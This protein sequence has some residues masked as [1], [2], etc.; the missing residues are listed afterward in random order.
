MTNER[1]EELAT[2]Y[3]LRELDERERAE[4]ERARAE[5]SEFREEYDD[6]E[7]TLDATN[8]RAPFRFDER[9]LAELRRTARARIERDLAKRNP[10]ER[11]A[12][13]FRGSAW[14][15]AL[16]SGLAMLAVGFFVRGALAGSDAN[17][18]PEPEPNYTNVRIDNVEGAEGML[19]ISYDAVR[20]VELEGTLEDPDVRRVVALAL[21]SD[22]N[23]GT[24]LR[25][26]DAIKESRA[27]LF[28]SETK[29]AL[30]VAATT[31]PNNG[32]RLEATRTLRRFPQDAELKEAYLRILR[33][34]PNPG[35]RVEAVEALAEAVE[36]IGKPDPKTIET[37]KTTMRDEENLYVRVRSEE[38]IEGVSL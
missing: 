19:R 37:L 12:D 35:V 21:T 27:P 17:E 6:L 23:P 18:T 2:G 20:R 3:W 4:F 10:I 9:D 31:D 33:L 25:S 36:R 5:R 29:R 28:D 16:A 34:D 7:R 38:I 14:R 11:I 26:V 30:I 1:F 13:W 15:P 32:V 24:R 8:R 22:E